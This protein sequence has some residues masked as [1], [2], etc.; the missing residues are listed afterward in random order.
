MI[1]PSHISEILEKEYSKVLKT[2]EDGTSQFLFYFLSYF[3]SPV[4]AAAVIEVFTSGVEF[5]DWHEVR[6]ATHRE[7]AEV[8][9]RFK[10]FDHNTV[11]AFIQMLLQYFWDYA[12]DT[13]IENLA[14]YED[15]I[16]SLPLNIRE[17]SYIKTFLKLANTGNIDIHAERILARLGFKFDGLEIPLPDEFKKINLLRFHHLLVEH[18]KRICQIG[19]PK[20]HKCPLQNQCLHFSETS[21]KATA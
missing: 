18:G 13:S 20:C 11:A 9:Q 3:N 4:N 17:K 8:L 5:S 7:I 21:K 10:I 19:N 12:D 16:D 14:E 2:Y 6:V 15:L 1:S